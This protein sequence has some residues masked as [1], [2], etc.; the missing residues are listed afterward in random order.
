MSLLFRM[1]Q[2][3]DLVHKIVYTLPAEL[4][5]SSTTTFL[6]PCMGKGDYLVMVAKR[7]REH[8]HSKK[9]ILNRLYG[10]E[11]NELYVQNC[12]Q[13]TPLDGAHIY[14]MTY[15]EVLEWEPEMKFDCV[16]TNP[17]YQNQNTEENNVRPIWPLFVEL[18]IGMVVDNGYVG[19]VT[20]TSW[21]GKPT[22]RTNNYSAFETYQIHHLELFDKASS[23]FSEGTTVSWFIM[24]KSV[25]DSHTEVVY[26]RKN[27]VKETTNIMLVPGIAL[28]N[29]LTKDGIT[30][31]EKLRKGKRME[32][33]QTYEFHTDKLNKHNL[34]SD[35]Q[36]KKYSNKYYVSHR[37]V[38]YASIQFGN[39]D[40]WKVMIPSSSTINNLVIDNNCGHAHD[41]YC[42]YASTLSEA[43]QIKSILLTKLFR[44][45][46][47]A[48]RDGPNLTSVFRRKVFPAVD[49]TR[50]WTDEQLYKHFKLTKKEIK[51]IEGTIK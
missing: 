4:F 24:Q 29:E 15:E 36:T 32:F 49:L 7:L 6:D 2:P 8:R 45:I 48:Y 37:I 21:I 43:K 38:R 40:C 47:H 13:K 30:L 22:N 27:T 10:I 50:S 16:I 20:P 51:L 17:P 25:R 33:I 31:G 12:L 46:G 26:N 39:Y 23:P 11:C 18:A 28:P 3:L 34:T 19:M 41:M 5:I 1:N 35:K 42:L 14:V 9:N 44:Y